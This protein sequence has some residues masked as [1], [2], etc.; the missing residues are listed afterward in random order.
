LYIGGQFNEYSYVTARFFLFI[1]LTFSIHQSFGDD[2]TLRTE[3]WIYEENIKTPIFYESTGDFNEMFNPPIVSLGQPFPLQLEF[4]DITKQT[5]RYYYR[6]IPCDR[7]WNVVN[8]NDSEFLREFI[9]DYLITGYVMSFNTRVKYVHYIFQVPKVKLSGNYLV[10]V[11]RNGNPDDIVLTR[12]FLVYENRVGISAN[13]RISVGVEERF[14]HQQVD[15][16]ISYGS[17]PYIFNPLQEVKVV[18]RQ[19]N[20]WDNALTT[21]KPLYVKETEKM[22]DYNFFNLE[23]NFPGGKEFRMFDCRKVRTNSI[24][25]E[26]TDFSPT[27][28]DVYLMREKSRNG[29]SYTN[30]FDADGRFVVANNEVGGAYNDP[31]YVNVNFDLKLSEMP[32]GSVYLLGFFNDWKIDPKYKLQY[33]SESETYK[34]KILLKQGYYNYIYAVKGIKDIKSDELALEGSSY[35][36]ENIYEIIVY[37]KPIGSRSD[38]IVGYY[39]VKFNGN[40]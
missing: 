22:L 32:F 5:D 11:Y 17:Y 31:D 20:R 6:I 40:N 23:N 30:Y 27:D 25:I 29:Q 16:T 13:V 39:S 21:L 9:N 10:M 1:F 34:A 4:D 38:L 12:R 2:K 7:D 15:F 8:L 14:T 19:N 3:D 33:D 24:N 26:K 18:V 35:Q 37:H 36:T 28:I